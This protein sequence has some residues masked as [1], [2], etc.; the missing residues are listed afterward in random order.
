MLE[1]AIRLA[2]HALIFTRNDPSGHI[3]PS[4]EDLSLA[5]TLCASCKLLGLRFLDNV[6]WGDWRLA[7][8]LVAHER[9]FLQSAPCYLLFGRIRGME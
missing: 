5:E 6:I 3:E 8:G 2:L 4:P 7:S 1:P 9:H